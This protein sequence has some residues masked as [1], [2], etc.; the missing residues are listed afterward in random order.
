MSEP[1][2]ASVTTTWQRQLH[3]LSPREREIVEAV[4]PIDGRDWAE[5]HIDGAGA[6]SG[7]AIGLAR[8]GREGFIRRR[9]KA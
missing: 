3:E 9:I 6:L 1:R 8:Q 4:F 2:D 5:S 7:S